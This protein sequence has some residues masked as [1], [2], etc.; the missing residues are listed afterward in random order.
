ML[1]HLKK[2]IGKYEMNMKYE[3]VFADGKKMLIQ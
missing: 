1:G 3:K 2:W